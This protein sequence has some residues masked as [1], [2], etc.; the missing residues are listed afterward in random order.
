ME[1]RLRKSKVGGENWNSAT[2]PF[3]VEGGIDILETYIRE[4]LDRNL[5]NRAGAWYTYG[6]TKAMGLNGIKQQFL[7]NPGLLETLKYAI[8]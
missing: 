3:R 4:G 1:V 6:D 2:V 7:E 8:A 5:I